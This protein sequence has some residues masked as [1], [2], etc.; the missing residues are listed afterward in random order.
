MTWLLKENYK[1]EESKILHTAGML[2]IE[3]GLPVY[4]CLLCSLKAGNR[5]N[6][7]IVE[8]LGEYKIHFRTLV[9][10]NDYVV[11]LNYEEEE[12][13][14]AFY[15]SMADMLNEK[16]EK[17]FFGVGESCM[18]IVQLPAVYTQAKQ[19][20]NFRMVNRECG[21]TFYNEVKKENFYFYPIENEYALR[22]CLLAGEYEKVS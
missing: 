17:Y 9:Y 12:E 21:I 14:A 18:S 2:G 6:K 11:I 22:N 8:I 5:L 15:K 3:F 16:A 7:E 13:A 4:N 10:Q 1:P 20:R 19:A